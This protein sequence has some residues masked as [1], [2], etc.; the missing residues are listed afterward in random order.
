MDQT[1]AAGVAVRVLGLRDFTGGEIALL[2]LRGIGKPRLRGPVNM[3]G[4]IGHALDQRVKVLGIE[5][6]QF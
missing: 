5:R 6:Q 4:K 2:R 1:S 3:G